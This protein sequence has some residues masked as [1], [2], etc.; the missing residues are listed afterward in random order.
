MSTQESIASISDETIIFESD[1][2]D[3][4][5]ETPDLSS[6]DLELIKRSKSFLFGDSS[7][8]NLV[9]GIIFYLMQ[10]TQFKNKN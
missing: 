1:F 7:T 4:L 9:F 10:L 2:N 3:A 5:Q 8:K 6:F